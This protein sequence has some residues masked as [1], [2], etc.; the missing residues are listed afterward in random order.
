MEGHAGR[1]FFMVGGI[2]KFIAGECQGTPH[3]ENGGHRWHSLGRAC[4]EPRTDTLMERKVHSEMVISRFSTNKAKRAN[5]HSSY[6]SGSPIDGTGIG[7]QKQGQAGGQAEDLP[8]PRDPHRNHREGP[9]RNPHRVTCSPIKRHEFNH[10]EDDNCR[11]ENYF[12]YND[13]TRPRMQERNDTTLIPK[14]YAI[15]GISV[16]KALIA[17]H[18]LYECR[19]KGITDLMDL[20][21]RANRGLMKA[22]RKMVDGAAH[23]FNMGLSKAIPCGREICGPK[24]AQGD[25][26]GQGFALKAPT[27]EAELQK[28]AEKVVTKTL[29]VIRITPNPDKENYEK[30][31]S[32]SKT[33]GRGGERIF[34]MEVPEGLPEEQFTKLIPDVFRRTQ[35]KI[36]WDARS[37]YIQGWDIQRLINKDSSCPRIHQQAVREGIVI[38]G[39]TRTAE[40]YNLH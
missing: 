26:D 36:F 11:E 3:A 16:I 32:A 19:A 25:H 18:A 9:Q 21:P 15:G 29:S 7:G 38:D 30:A 1:P 23:V 22:L 24:G 10:D 20:T 27:T 28:Q 2:R 35:K 4:A 33:W 6:A 14:D 37:G 31:K 39:T 5:L 17:A 40:P 13:D 34:V 12:F 8:P